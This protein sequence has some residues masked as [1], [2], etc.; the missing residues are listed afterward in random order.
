MKTLTV[1]NNDN[2]EG[3]VSLTNVTGVL[4]GTVSFNAAGDV[5]Y[6][7]NPDFNGT[8]TLTYTITED[9]G[10]TETGTVSVTI[11]ATG[12]IVGD[13]ATVDEE[14]SVDIKVYIFKGCT[15]PNNLTFFDSLEMVVNEN[16]FQANPPV[17]G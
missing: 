16:F 7:P 14:D 11:N 1:L 13:V 2:F 3:T 5:T 12:N 15:D 4:N 9:D 17:P 6:S 8:E 10:S